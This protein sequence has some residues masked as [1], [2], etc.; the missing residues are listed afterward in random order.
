MP[1]RI[2]TAIFLAILLLPVMA[3]DWRHRVDSLQDLLTNE[4]SDTNRINIYLRLNTILLSNEP[5][6]AMEYA[7]SAYQLSTE[8]NYNPGIVKSMLQ[9]CDFYIIVGEYN[10]ALE[11]AYKALELAE[12]DPRLQAWCHNRIGTVHDAV[13]NSEETL[14]HNKK[15][16]HFSSI[17][18]DSGS[19][20]VDIHNIGRVYTDLGHYDSALY[21]LRIANK[22]E[23]NHKGRPDP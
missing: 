18:G 2:S 9:Q 11:M 17:L 7:V 10:T 3:G 14:L 13:G 22:Y 8:I 23:I 5:E 19:I 20:I 16:L 1:K 4:T 15:S 12:P 21:Y 6:Q